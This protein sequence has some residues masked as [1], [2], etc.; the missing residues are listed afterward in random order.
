MGVCTSCRENAGLGPSR[1][2]PALLL[3]PDQPFRGAPLS[4]P[5]GGLGEPRTEMLTSPQG[6]TQEAV[7]QEQIHIPDLPPTLV[8]CR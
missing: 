5:A 2:C 7:N 6:L 8:P 4:V 3:G 1:G